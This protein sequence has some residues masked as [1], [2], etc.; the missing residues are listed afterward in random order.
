MTWISEN[1]YIDKLGD[2]VKKCSNTYHRI[3]KMKSADVR[4][5]SINFNK[6]NS[7]VIKILYLKL[8]IMSK[9]QNIKT[10]FQRVTFQIGPQKFLFL[11]KLKILCRRRI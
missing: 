3:S 4:S 7:I 10:F 5:K 8:I 11:K 1:V 2:I 9:N 6:K